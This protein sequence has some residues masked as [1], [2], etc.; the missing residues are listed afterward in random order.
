M[1]EDEEGTGLRGT[2]PCQHLIVS[3][4]TTHLAGSSSFR[5]WWKEDEEGNWALH[6]DSAIE[7]DALTVSLLLPLPLS[8]GLAWMQI[9]WSSACRPGCE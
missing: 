1:V 6:G 5:Q 3:A 9:S 7:V 8:H 2:S 4:A